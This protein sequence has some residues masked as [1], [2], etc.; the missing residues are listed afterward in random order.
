M[1]PII[2]RYDGRW[3]ENKKYVDFR[4]TGYLV[5]EGTTYL[6]FVEFLFKEP[7]LGLDRL[8]YIYIYDSFVC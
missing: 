3:D 7:Y 8:R 2:I 5:K 1:I 6:E 4:F